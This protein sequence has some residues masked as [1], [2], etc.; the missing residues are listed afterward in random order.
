M[1]N[2]SELSEC[3]ME[4]K[5]CTGCEECNYCDLHEEKVC[6]NCME[7]VDCVDESSDFRAIKIEGVKYG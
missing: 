3:V 7:C 6:N 5:F 1:D 4:H 2:P